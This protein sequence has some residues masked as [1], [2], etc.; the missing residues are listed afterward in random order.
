MFIAGMRDV[1]PV[2]T[3]EEL[4]NSDAPVW[5]AVDLDNIEA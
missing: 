3:R 2:G 4:E 1:Q 5:S